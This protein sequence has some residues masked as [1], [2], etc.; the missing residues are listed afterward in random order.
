ML[1]ASISKHMLQNNLLSPWY[2]L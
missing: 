2:T 1:L